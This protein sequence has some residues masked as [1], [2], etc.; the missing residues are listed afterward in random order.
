MAGSV[1]RKLFEGIRTFSA[2]KEGDKNKINITWHYQVFL[3]RGFPV[4]FQ[5]NKRHVFIL[6]Y[7][8]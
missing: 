7:N 2:N 4:R 3:A 5:P 6:L 1:H 8:I